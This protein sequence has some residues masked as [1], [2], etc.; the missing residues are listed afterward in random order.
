M[1]ARPCSPG[2]L[3]RDETHDHVESHGRRPLSAVVICS[4]VWEMF[5][6]DSHNN[7]GPVVSTRLQKL[8][9]ARLVRFLEGFDHGEDRGAVSAA[10]PPLRKSSDVALPR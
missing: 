3:Y 4:C 8:L 10:S 7:I 2:V 5:R 6:V 9:L 1:E